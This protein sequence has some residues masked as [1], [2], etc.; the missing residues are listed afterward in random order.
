MPLVW[1]AR[2]RI[3]AGAARGLAFI[4]HASRRGGSGSFKLA[5]DN[6]KSTNIFIGRYGEARLADCGLAQL[7]GS[8]SSS[9]HAMVSWGR[10]SGAWPF[11]EDGYDMRAPCH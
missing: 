3:A 10:W 2:I 1:A 7:S 11:E 8:S 9:A 6:I 5:H 4:H